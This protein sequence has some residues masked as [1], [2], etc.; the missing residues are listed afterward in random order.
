MPVLFPQVYFIVELKNEKNERQKMVKKKNRRRRK[1]RWKGK[2]IT[3]IGDREVHYLLQHDHSN[4]R[5]HGGNIRETFGI[6]FHEVCGE[7]LPVTWGRGEK[8][9]HN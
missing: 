1:K 5:W 7:V 3:R 9:A 2:K 6:L 8:K 4:S